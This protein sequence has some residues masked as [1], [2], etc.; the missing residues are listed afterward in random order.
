MMRYP[1][2]I[3]TDCVYSDDQLIGGTEY[4]KRNI[5]RAPFKGQ[6]SAN[7]IICFIMKNPSFADKH[8]IDKT[9]S[10]VLHYTYQ[11]KQLDQRFLALS[12]VVIVNLFAIYATVSTTLVDIIEQNGESFVIG[13][14]NDS[15]IRKAVSE[16]SF[17]VPAWGR[18]PKNFHDDNT[19]LYRN[20]IYSVF[21]DILNS[22]KNDVVN[23]IGEKKQK[24]LY[25]MHPE[26][27]GY[28]DKQAVNKFALNPY[29]IKGN[30]LVKV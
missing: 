26:R 6:Y 27:I 7:Q 30:F 9:V 13:N 1:D 10:N 8:I 12:E 14:G 3:D 25:P 24:K 15:S 29:I 22:D 11:L 23:L 2:F 18:K 4:R 20:R 16:A 21:S 28:K 19:D 17:I 5:L